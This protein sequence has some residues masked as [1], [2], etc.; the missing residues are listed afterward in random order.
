MVE[1][2]D[3]IT[4]TSLSV[5]HAFPAV[6]D[7]Y[8]DVTHRHIVVLIAP[9]SDV[10]TVELPVV[11]TPIRYGGTVGLALVILLASVTA[12]SGD[13]PRT[14]FGIGLTTYLH[15]VAYAVLAGSIGYAHRSADRRTILLAA[16]IATGYGA[17][18]ELIQGLLPYRTMA[19]TDVLINAVGA[20][21]GATCWWLL[22]TWFAGSRDRRSKPSS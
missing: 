20:S 16:S 4:P 12:P 6:P 21:V 5:M 17:G 22:A 2:R 1:L 7:R 15:L 18:I 14:A 19:L 8:D 10:Q 3:P 13:L 11:P 9:H